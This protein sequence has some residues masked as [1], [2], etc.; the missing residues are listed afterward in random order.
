M[1][2]AHN[3]AVILI[4]LLIDAV[5]GDPDAVWRRFAHPVAL[6]GRAI[7]W[8]D[9]RFNRLELDEAVRRRRG[10]WTLVALV[11]SAFAVGVAISWSLRG[12]PYG[13][14]IEGAIASVFLAQNSLHRHV[15]AVLK[16]W[17]AGGLEAAR[18]AVSMIVG[19][20]PKRLDEAGVARAAIE[21]CA[22]NF[23]DGVIAP[24][25]W[26][27]A[28]GLPGLIA[29][30]AIN[31]ADS[32]IGHNSERHRAF[33]WA[34][35]RFDDWVNLAPARLSGA[36]I[37][38]AALLT[39]RPWREAWRAMLR[40]APR[41]ASPNAGWPEAAMGGALGLALAG[42]RVYAGVKVDDPYMNAGGGPARME[43]ISRALALFRAACLLG[44]VA[45]AAV[46]L[47]VSA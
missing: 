41:H 12:L 21:S 35:A 26:G 42:P 1:D 33:G 28:L 25:V 29:Y 18:T 23:A 34:S 13:V 24:M 11:V 32:M 44:A 47:L 6:I 15:S 27:V 39:G 37:V 43:D 19:R 45:V 3:A 8:A 22:E 10:V 16:A 7:G 4:A 46:W 30:K 17:R 2:L 20:D 31:T 14:L 38:L 5:V 40:D 9:A 36:L